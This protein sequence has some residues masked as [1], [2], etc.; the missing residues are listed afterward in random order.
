MSEANK[1]GLLINYEYCTGCHSCEVACKKEHDFPT[2]EYGIKLL[3]DGIRKNIDGIWEYTY[4]PLPTHMCD[5]CADRVSEGRLPTCCHHC[6]SGIMW[7]DTVENLAELI[8]DKPRS[9]IFTPL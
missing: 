2:G 5:L 1:Y 8:K 9:C 3:F 7:Y 6:Q 4:L